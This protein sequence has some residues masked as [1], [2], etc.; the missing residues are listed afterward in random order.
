MKQN[1]KVNLV[2]L[3]LLVGFALIQVCCSGVLNLFYIQILEQI[4]INIILAVA[5][6]LIDSSSGQFSLRH[7][8][9]GVCCHLQ[10]FLVPNPKPM[11]LLWCD[12]FRC[13]DCWSRWALIIRFQTFRL[14]GATSQLRHLGFWKSFRSLIVMVVL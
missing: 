8:V 3:G 11:G 4:G 10:L 1:L 14:K 12:G 5:L 9:Y 7:A 13:F 6:N 2:W